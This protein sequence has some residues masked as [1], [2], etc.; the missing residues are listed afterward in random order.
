M[1]HCILVFL[2]LLFLLIFLFCMLLKA[3]LVK[4]VFVS[5]VL[6][7]IPSDVSKAGISPDL[8]SVRLFCCPAVLIQFFKFHRYVLS[9]V[10]HWPTSL[11]A[12]DQ[13]SSHSHLRYFSSSPFQTRPNCPCWVHDSSIQPVPEFRP[14]LPP[15]SFCP[16]FYFPVWSGFKGPLVVRILSNDTSCSYCFF[17]RYKLLLCFSSIFIIISSTTVFLSPFSPLK[18]N[19]FYIQI[20]LL[21]SISSWF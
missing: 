6:A 18:I 19:L 20:W 1:E 4:G 14:V 7:A 3:L 10:F 5:L 15:F 8:I 11:W 17:L 12:P 2:Q 13:D 16:F 21:P 9:P